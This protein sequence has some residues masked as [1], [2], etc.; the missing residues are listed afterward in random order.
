MPSSPARGG[1]NSSR[2]DPAWQPCSLLHL[3]PPPG[4]GGLLGKQIPFMSVALSHSQV[5]PVVFGRGAGQCVGPNPT[6]YA[7]ERC[8]L[9]ACP[10]APR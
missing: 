4:P 3:Q 2:S 8:V 6:V 1:G 7:R 5:F 9:P 10:A